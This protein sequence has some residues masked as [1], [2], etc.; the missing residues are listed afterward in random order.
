[1]IKMIFGLVFGTRNDKLIR[2]YQ[3][4]VNAI[5]TL[6]STFETLSDSELQERFNALKT[7]VQD[8]GEE[9]RFCAK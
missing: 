2:S 3:K 8:D 6:E 9:L 1:M 4:R 7:R 5:N